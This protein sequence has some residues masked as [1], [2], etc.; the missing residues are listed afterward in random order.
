MGAPEEITLTD[1]HSLHLEKDF[2]V[3]HFSGTM[4]YTYSL[5][6]KQI[7]LQDNLCLRLDLGRVEVIAEVL[8]NGVFAGTCWAPPYSIDIQHLLHKGDNKIEIRVTN[9]WVNRL[10]G[11]EY[12]PVENTYSYQSIQNKFSALHN[13]GIEKLPDWYVQGRPKPQ[14]SRIAFCTWKHYDKTSPL[15]ESGLLGPVIL[16]VGKIE[17]IKISES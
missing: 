14:G 1:L 8:V 4:T 2:G 6:L 9:L 17:N 15:V 11:D 16:K 13:G 10:I 7:Y 12:L 3:R 5:L